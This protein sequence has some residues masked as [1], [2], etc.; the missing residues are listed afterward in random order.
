[1]RRFP[2][3]PTSQLQKETRSPRPCAQSIFHLLRRSK[4]DMPVPAQL[5][6]RSTRE[7][8]IKF[9]LSCDDVKPFHFSIKPDAVN[10]QRHRGNKREDCSSKI[11]RRAFHEI[12]PN[13]PCSY[14]ECEQRRENDENNMESLKR[15]LTNDRVVVPRK[16]DKPEESEHKKTS[17]YKDAVNE[18]F[19]RGQVHE[20]CRNQS[21]L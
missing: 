19:F 10:D 20:N 1:M 14:P 4:T 2:P 21:R 9:S 3:G 6:K 8:R 16:K 13:A 12:D 7:K 17:K 18:P 5:A 15:H 11:N